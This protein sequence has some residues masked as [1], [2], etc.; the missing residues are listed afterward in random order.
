MTRKGMKQMFDIPDH[1][2]IQNLMRTGYPDGKEPKDFK[3]PVCGG[4]GELY[5]LT[6]SKTIVGCD[7]CVDAIEWWEVIDHE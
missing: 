1:P 2:I 6:K 7:L 3:C 5:Y 4:D